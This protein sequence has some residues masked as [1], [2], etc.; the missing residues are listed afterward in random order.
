M[1]FVAFFFYP[2]S[3]SIF[4]F[5]FCI[6][7]VITTS[8]TINLSLSSYFFFGGFLYI[9]KLFIVVVVLIVNVDMF[10]IM[11]KEGFFEVVNVWD[12][13]EGRVFSCRMWSEIVV[14]FQYAF[15]L[16]QL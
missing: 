13:I 11:L 1:I 4:F 5:F 3:L 9:L 2:R 15:F 7:Q 14:T 12:Y 16:L 8:L 10:G 6:S